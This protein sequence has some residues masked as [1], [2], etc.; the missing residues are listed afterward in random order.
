M[1]ISN[2]IGIKF[3]DFP[4]KSTKKFAENDLHKKYINVVSAFVDTFFN[5]IVNPTQKSILNVVLYVSQ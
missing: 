4:L 1:R 5:I 3:A 2:N